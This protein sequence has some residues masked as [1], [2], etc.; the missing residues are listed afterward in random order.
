MVLRLYEN[1]IISRCEIT[2]LGL[3]KE[4]RDFVFLE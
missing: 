4:V 3:P 1:V 2:L